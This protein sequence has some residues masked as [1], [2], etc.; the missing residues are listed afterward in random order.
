MDKE[1][2]EPTDSDQLRYQLRNRTSTVSTSSS[3]V[4]AVSHANL[5]AIGGRMAEGRSEEEATDAI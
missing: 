3:Q 5:P 2:I 4:A 1:S